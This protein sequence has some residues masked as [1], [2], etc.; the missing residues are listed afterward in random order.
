AL[1]S[2]GLRRC[3]LYADAW[4]HDSRLCL[5]NVRAA[6]QAGAS[7]LNYAEVIELRIERGRVGGAEVV[8][9]GA[10]VSVRARAVVNATGP[11]IDALGARRARLPPRPARAAERRRRKADDVPTDRARRSPRA[12]PHT[13]RPDAAAAP[14]RRRPARGRRP[15]HARLRGA[16]ATLG[17]APRAP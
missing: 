7:V 13:G 16:R 17:R 5:A 15:P 4:T 8:A 14:G 1:R 3:G 11:W 6:A 12:R 9:D 2:D 10:A